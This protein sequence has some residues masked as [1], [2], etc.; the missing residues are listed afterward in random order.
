MRL[1]L[2]S[3]IRPCERRRRE[4]VVVTLAPEFSGRQL[5]Q[6]VVHEQEHLLHREFRTSV[7]LARQLNKVLDVNDVYSK[8]DGRAVR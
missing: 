1:S 5:V 4:R 2:L 7:P 3:S 8:E 6:L